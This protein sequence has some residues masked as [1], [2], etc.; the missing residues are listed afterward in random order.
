MKENG[1]EILGKPLGVN[2]ERE[3]KAIFAIAHF[4]AGEMDKEELN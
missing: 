4:P 3:K 2:T 1:T